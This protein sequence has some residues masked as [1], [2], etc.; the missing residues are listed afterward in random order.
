MGLPLERVLEVSPKAQYRGF[1]LRCGAAGA[2][3]R[4]INA[5]A[6]AMLSAERGHPPDS[7]LHERLIKRWY[8][9]LASGNPDYGVYAEDEYL[10]EGWLC[11]RTYSRDYLRA[12]SSSKSLASGIPFNA[13]YKVRSIA[14]L[15]CGIGYTTVGL[16]QLW[17]A[18]DVVGTNVAGSRQERIVRQLGGQYL[19]RCE[20]RGMQYVGPRDLVFASEYFEHFYAP[21]DHLREVLTYVQPKIM[22]IANAF[23]SRACGHFPEYLVDG[24]VLPGKI[25]SRVFNATLREAGYTKL[26]FNAWN[27]RPLVW[28]KRAASSTVPTPQNTLLT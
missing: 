20:C 22:V 24:K 25:T 16:R 11:W 10:A 6:L 3:V 18:A 23:T 9:S 28:I 4:A 5:M 15:G 2:D 26:A 21:V 27:G 17:P 8:A 1:L 13:T 14:D 19:F 7:D 12:L